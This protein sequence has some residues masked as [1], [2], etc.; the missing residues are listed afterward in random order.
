MWRR[1]GDIP[2]TLL[3]F[4]VFSFEVLSL[5]FVTWTFAGHLFGLTPYREAQ[6]VLV[7]WR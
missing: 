1:Y 6:G 3:V 4:A 7:E 2:Y 5:A